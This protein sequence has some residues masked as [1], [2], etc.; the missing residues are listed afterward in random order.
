VK[1]REA[2]IND[3]NR[4]DAFVDSEGGD[5]YLYYDW[6]QFYETRDDL[7]IPLMIQSDSSQLLGIFPLVKEKKFLYSIL[8]SLPEG[9]GDFLI[10]NDLSDSE[11]HDVLC[12]LAKYVDANYAKGCAG[13][14]I[15]GRITYF[16]KRYCVPD[17]AR[18]DS[19]LR[20]NYNETT[21]FPCTHIIK[22]NGSF[23]EYWNTLPR[24]LKQNINKATRN[25]V[26]IIN[27]RELLYQNEFI[28]M[29]G[30]NYK[31]HKNKRIIDKETKVKIEVFKQKTKLYIALLKGQPIAGLLC[32]YTPLTCHLAKVGSY[33]RENGNAEKLCF[34]VAIE[35]AYAAG[36]KYV[37]FNLSNDQNTAFYKGQF[38]ATRIPA[39]TYEKKYSTLRYRL[40]QA[41]EVWEI[42][43]KD[44]MYLWNNR[45][46]IWRKIFGEPSKKS[47]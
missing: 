25:G 16:D 30:E 9:G 40:Y 31:R 14:F 13:L 11:K 20:Y 42:L 22:V 6:K 19:G 46:K 3:K 32:Q 36:Y 39:G 10:K 15:K 12:A 24:I 47:K 5:Y 21:G 27:D 26:T 44:K 18:I 45:R 37:D 34:K 17:N 1:I 8:E 41:F 23:K 7:F 28:A 38:K 33:T 2:D 29:L 4:W 35:E 43:R